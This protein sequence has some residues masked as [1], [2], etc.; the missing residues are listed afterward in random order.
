MT[1]TVVKVPI[2]LAVLRLEALIVRNIRA[3]FDIVTVFI[4]G[5]NG[6]TIRYYSAVGELRVVRPQVTDGYMSRS[7]VT[8]F[9]STY[10]KFLNK[11]STGVVTWDDGYLGAR[12][13]VLDNAIRV[14][15]VDANSTLVDSPRFR[16]LEG[17]LREKYGSLGTYMLPK[18]FIPTITFPKPPSRKVDRKV[19]HK[20]VLELDRDVIA[21]CMLEILSKGHAVIPWEIVAETALESAWSDIFGI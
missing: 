21:R 13:R 20:S 9:Y 10:S 17:D 16:D 8:E 6:E 4:V 7:Y 3:P 2:V 11:V 15:S 1:P 12:S 18:Y 5:T 14:L 19:L